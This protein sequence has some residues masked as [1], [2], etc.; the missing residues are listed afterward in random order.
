MALQHRSFTF[1]EGDLEGIA[2]EMRSV[3]HPGSAATWMNIV[4]DVDEREVHTG[5]IFWRVLSSRGP[6]IPTFTWVPAHTEGTRSNPCEVGILHAAGRDAIRR[7]EKEG[8]SVPDGWVL[9]QD[10]TKRGVIL[11]VPPGTD[12]TEILRYAVRVLPPLSP[13]AFEPY[14]EARFSSR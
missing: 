4:P 13:F 5:S 7:L 9:E 1:H 2:A 3:A 10:H 8:V 11:A 14:Y 12:E 6:V